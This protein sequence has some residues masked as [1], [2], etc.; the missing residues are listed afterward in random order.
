MEVK[1]KSMKHE[2]F[3]DNEY[4]DNL[5]EQLRTGGTN[6]IVGKLD[7]LMNWGVSNSL[8]PLCFGT[9]DSVDMS[10]NKLRDIVKDGETWHA[11]VQ[12]VVVGRNLATEQPQQECMHTGICV[13]LA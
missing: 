10:L 13:P 7:Q 2:D 1:I 11:V 12:G 5:V 4:I 9:T 3:K 6:I 8:W